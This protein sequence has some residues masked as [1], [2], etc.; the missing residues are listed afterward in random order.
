MTDKT[1]IQE[2]AQAYFCS[3]AD[4][5]GLVSYKKAKKAFYDLSLSNK[6]YKPTFEDFGQI[7]N[8][9]KFKDSFLKEAYDKS[10]VDAPGV[11]F[12]EIIKLLNEDPDWLKSSLN[13]AET[14]FE[15]IGKIEKDLV[16]ITSKGWKDI[17]YVRGDK[18]IMGNISA[19]F[20]VAK[21]NLQKNPA[22]IKNIGGVKFDNINKW[23]TA[24]IYLGSKD[25]KKKINETLKI[26]ELDFIQLNKLI[27]DL[28][29]SGDLL[30]LSLKKQPNKVTIKKVNFNRKK[31]EEFLSEIRYVGKNDWKPLYAKDDGKGNITFHYTKNSK[32][33][34]TGASV[35]SGKYIAFYYTNKESLSKSQK[36]QINFRHDPSGDSGGAYK[37][38]IITG[39]EARGGSVSGDMI[40]DIMMLFD[41]QL[42]NK[43]KT[44]HANGKK[45]F[46]DAKKEFS[47][48]SKPVYSK[49]NRSNYPKGKSPYDL[50]MSEL[51][52]K[53]ISNELNSLLIDFFEN[54]KEETSDARIR[55]FVEYAAATSLGSAKFILAK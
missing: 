13:I 34:G 51:S 49:N 32:G 11:S 31:E 17:F 37:A 2:A 47:K 54:S 55:K 52:N 4:G 41:K 42:A 15:E 19:L 29:D 39:P 38:E 1:A 30:P 40:S 44:A 22:K 8:T 48:N 23:S 36:Y 35:N 6:R 3:V 20:G 9:L 46:K 53:Y 45:A 16:K 12:N 50:K 27:S 21:K 10:Y 28:I 18:E 33:E 26:K 24:D 43:F 25:A 14:L 7:L 5:M